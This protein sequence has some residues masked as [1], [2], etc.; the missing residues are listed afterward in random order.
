MRVSPDASRLT[1]KLRKCKVKAC[2]KQFVPAKPF[3]DWCSDD[4]AHALALEKLAK[5]KERV[6]RAERKADKVKREKLKTRGDWMRE[7]QQAFNAFIRER[8]RQA[9][10]SCICCGE[11]LDWSGNN[12]DAGHYRS[13]GSA[14]HMRFVDNNCWAQTKKCNRYQAGR[15]VDYRIGLIKRIGM[16]AVEALESDQT[17]R[18]WS[19][20]E[21]QEIKATYRRRL[22]E[23]VANQCSA[24]V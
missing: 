9:G 8:D 2:R 4:C 19:I 23:L 14:P 12:V 24:T 20:T 13:R 16:E 5:I 7:A 18:K 15:A 10:H 11:P 17:A 21:L 3:I 1:V 6:V 22:K